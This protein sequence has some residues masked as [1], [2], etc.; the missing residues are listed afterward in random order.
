[1]VR[2]VLVWVAQMRKVQRTSPWAWA[3]YG[4]FA[5]AAAAWLVI[6][7]VDRA[8]ASAS[9][10]GLTLVLWTFAVVRVPRRRAAA[11]A[12]ADRAEAAALTVLGK[13]NAA[14]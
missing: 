12:K 10:A 5:A 14:Q 9:T 1:L 13:N 11:I 4:L 8:P 6:A 7:L 3:V 2:A